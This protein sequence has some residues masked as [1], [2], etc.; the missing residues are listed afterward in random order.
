MDACISATL[1]WALG[2]PF[3]YGDGTDDDGNAVGS[4]I[5]GTRYFFLI[6]AEDLIDNDPTFLGNWMFQW[7]FAATCATIVS[8]AVAERC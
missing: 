8:G 1:W 7:A 2:Y 4:P 3:A 6:G 5:I